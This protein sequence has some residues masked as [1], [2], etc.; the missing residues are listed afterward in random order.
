M[1]HEIKTK[2][3]LDWLTLLA[4][5]FPDETALFDQDLKEE[6][7]FSGL[8]ERI[9]Q[10]GADLETA[11]LAHGQCVMIALPDGP[12]ALIYLMATASYA[13]AIPVPPHESES[14]YEGIFEQLGVS[15]VIMKER[16][17]AVLTQ[18]CEKKGTAV[19]IPNQDGVVLSM[20]Q[21][22]TTP[23][24]SDWVDISII[25]H[26]SGSVNQPNLLGFSAEIFIDNIENFAK[27]AGFTRKDRLLCMMPITHMHSLWRSSIAV[28]S[29]G[30]SVCWTS[31][32]E[33]PA[34]SRWLDS[35]RPTFF[36]LTSTFHRQLIAFTN[37]EKYQAPDSLRMVG[38]GSEK[39]DS[40]LLA[41][42]HH[43]LRAQ[44][45]HFYGM[46]QTC[47]V[48]A[49]S[50]PDRPDVNQ[51]KLRINPLWE[52]RIADEDGKPLAA[53]ENGEILLKGGS[54]SKVLGGRVSE[55]T[56]DGYFRT[57]DTGIVGTDGYLTVSGRLDD[58]ITRGGDKINPADIE[59]EALVLNEVSEAYAFAVP[60]EVHG[61]KPRLW[62]GANQRLLSS[63]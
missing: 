26:T 60:D 61:Q 50:E 14:F 52:L 20:G 53:G 23:R 7:R 5:K 37:K 49:T 9:K 31:G 33:L 40:Q 46:S 55:F 32:F 15:A 1:N 3:L 47:P 45:L 13:T 22:I 43:K 29:V 58:R 8:L 27:L 41:D 44:T 62:S 57:G 2:S 39:V 51:V 48:V 30:G 16:P 10:I 28:W 21:V 54:Y 18:I 25:S 24:E 36:S 4:G 35:V 11:G 6:W 59:R 34:A 19:F 42:I 56:T 12:E 38:I 63:N 17:Y